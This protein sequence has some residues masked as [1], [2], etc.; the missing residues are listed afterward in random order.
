MSIL[1]N[2]GMSLLSIASQGIFGLTFVCM[3]PLSHILLVLY[4]AN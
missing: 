2:L 4:F 3:L 1:K